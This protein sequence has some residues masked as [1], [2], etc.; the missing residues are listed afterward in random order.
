MNQSVTI[1]VAALLIGGVGGFIAGKSGGSDAAGDSASVERDAKFRREASAVHQ[2]GTAPESRAR[3]IKEALR[4]PGQLARLQ[5]LVDLYEGM[6]LEELAAAADSLDDLPMADRIMAS[7]LLFSRWGEADP[8]G[9]LAYSET[10]G[11]GGMFARP[12]I[13]RSWASV[14]PVNAAKYYA[15]HP[16]EFNGP[17][18]RRGPGGEGGADLV[19]REW[20]KLDPDAAMAWA[21]S[22]E[23]DDKGSAMI[24]IVGEVAATDPAKAATMAATLTGDDQMRAYGEIA[25][26]WAAEDFSAAESWIQT[27]SGE[28]KDRAMSEAVQVLARTDPDAAAAKLASISEG[29]ARDRAVA[30]LA[31]EMAQEDPAAAASWLGNQ[32]TGDYGDAMRRIMTNWTAQDSAGA[33]SF[34][35]A[36]PVGEIRDSATQTYLWQNQDVEPSQAMS[37]AE[38]ITDERN[39]DRTIGMTARRWMETDET[40]AR[41]YVESSDLLSDRAKQ[42][43]LDGRG[44][45]GWGGRGRGR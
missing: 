39:R 17:G 44:G 21:N 4:E 5:S 38:A 34:I 43:I 26:K 18:G 8:Q 20:A 19:A 22:L 16:N 36:Q 31:G 3:S 35:E 15:E 40:A 6:S 14:D 9:A 12:T 10:M 1:G 2:D 11:F 25:Q 7:I 30:I 33:L 13:L 27:L 28:A 37:L 42:R 32:Q 24:S 41:A 23:G 29:G 45:P